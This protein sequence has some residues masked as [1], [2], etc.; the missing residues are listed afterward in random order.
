MANW[1]RVYVSFRRGHGTRS[2]WNVSK[3]LR[4]IVSLLRERAR[5]RGKTAFEI[6]RNAREGRE[7]ITKK[8]KTADLLSLSPFKEIIIIRSILSLFLNLNAS[9]FK[10]SSLSRFFLILHKNPI[11]SENLKLSRLSFIVPFNR[12]ILRIRTDSASFVQFK[13]FQQGRAGVFHH[14]SNNKGKNRDGRVDIYLSGGG[15]QA[16]YS[17]FT[18]NFWFRQ[19][20]RIRWQG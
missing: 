8:K 9:S 16:Q 6:K 17:R 4:K 1:S 19:A 12:M 7:N 10:P 11:V 14:R 20:W 3:L 18:C 2:R 15:A 13:S 5:A